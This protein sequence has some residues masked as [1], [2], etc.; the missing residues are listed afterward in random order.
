MEDNAKI[1][2]MEEQQER[3]VEEAWVMVEERLD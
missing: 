3:E 1:G 2:K